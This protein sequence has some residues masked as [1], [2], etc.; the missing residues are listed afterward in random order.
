M[1][2]S[3]YHRKL[4]LGTKIHSYIFETCRKINTFVLERNPKADDGDYWGLCPNKKAEIISYIDFV[5]HTNDVHYPLLATFED[6]LIYVPE[7]KELLDEFN[8]EPY[9]GKAIAGN[10]GTHKH[11]FSPTSMWNMCVM[12]K[13][14][15]HSIIRFHDLTDTSKIYYDP[16]FEY[17]YDHLQN[18]EPLITTCEFE[19]NPNE[20]YSLNVWNWHSF[21]VPDHKKTDTYLFYFKDTK[22]EEDIDKIIDRLK[23]YD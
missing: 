19:S 20:I 7:F 8:L 16:S 22:T 14:T 5:H 17:F 4:E 10:W 23:K 6:A 21:Y 12:D 15:E 9:F 1:L 3:P 13:N 18:S 11:V 2:K